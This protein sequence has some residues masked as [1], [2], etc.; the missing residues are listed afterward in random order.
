MGAVGKLF[1]NGRSQAVRIP[2][3]FR[4]EG[5]EVEF[6]PGPN[7][8]EVI[9]S[10]RPQRTGKWDAFLQAVSELKPEDIPEGFPWRDRRPH[11]RD[12]FA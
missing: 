1:M 11:D 7:P 4:F 2:A 12:P 9:L 6:R 3:E 10:P 8:G 5:T